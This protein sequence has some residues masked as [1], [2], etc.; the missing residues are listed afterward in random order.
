MIGH[1]ESRWLNEEAHGLFD[2]LVSEMERVAAAPFQMGS[3]AIVPSPA[4][5]RVE[6]ALRMELIQYL[7]DEALKLYVAYT[8]SVIFIPNGEITA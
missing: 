4:Q 6:L 7:R 1:S 8:A 2:D 5:L 3:G